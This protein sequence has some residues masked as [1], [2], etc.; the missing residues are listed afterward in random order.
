MVDEV[1]GFLCYLHNWLATPLAWVPFLFGLLFILL[2]CGVRPKNARIVPEF[3]SFQLPERFSKSQRILLLLFGALLAGIPTA[4]L[5][6]RLSA[7]SR[8]GVDWQSLVRDGRAEHIRAMVQTGDGGFAL[9]GPR[10][11]S[12]DGNG[13]KGFSVTRLDPQGQQVWQ[14]EYFF[15][16]LNVASQIVQ[17][18][19]GDLVVAGYRQ[20]LAQYEST[21]VFLQPLRFADGSE[22][23]EFASTL[24]KR[25]GHPTLAS[26]SGEGVPRAANRHPG[27]RSRRSNRQLDPG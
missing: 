7:D 27:A 4:N 2:G 16:N 5:V 18:S 11:D 8:I 14:Q 24:E 19:D 26:A 22:S 20:S 23:D 13:R 17:R 15:E 25:S 21:T 6:I 10:S 3:F 12:S 1:I 9:V